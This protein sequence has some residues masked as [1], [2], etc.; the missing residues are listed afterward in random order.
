[1]SAGHERVL[2]GGRGALSARAADYSQDRAFWGSAHDAERGSG[3]APP[4]PRFAQSSTYAPT[5][6]TRSGGMRYQRA[7]GIEFWCRSAKRRFRHAAMRAR[8]VGRIVTWST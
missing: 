8:P 1:M 7:T 2:L 3:E 4:L 6:N 5:S